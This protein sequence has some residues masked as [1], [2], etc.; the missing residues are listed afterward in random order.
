MIASSAPMIAPSS[1]AG[2]SMNHP[3]AAKVIGYTAQD[4]P[5]T[6]KSVISTAN[7]P[8]PLARLSRRY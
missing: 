3:M 1:R 6:A 8:R 7:Q 2:L 4:A 5:S